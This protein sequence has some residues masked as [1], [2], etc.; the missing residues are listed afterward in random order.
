MLLKVIINDYGQLQDRE[1][2]LC[3][4]FK[5]DAREPGA[6]LE[7]ASCIH[8]N[9]NNKNNNNILDHQIFVINSFTGEI[10]SPKVDRDL[11][12]TVGWPFLN[13]IA[14]TSIETG[15]TKVIIMNEASIPTSIVIYDQTKSDYIGFAIHERSIQTIVY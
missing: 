6:L 10:T 1:T 2:G 5:G 3:I 13:T 12:L 4:S 8:N 14:F 11:C 7:L 15:K 9:I